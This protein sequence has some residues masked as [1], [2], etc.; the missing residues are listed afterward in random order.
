MPDTDSKYEL[1]V[2]THFKKMGRWV[3]QKTL[4]LSQSIKF[5]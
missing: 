4:D 2:D 1:K 3:Q 5:S